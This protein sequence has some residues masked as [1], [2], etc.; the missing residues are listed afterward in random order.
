MDKLFRDL[1][2]KKKLSRAFMIIIGCSILSVLVSV[3]GIFMVRNQLTYFY[4]TPYKSAVAA[5]TYRRDLNSIMRN[6]LRS[7]TTNDLSARESYLATVQKDL[8]D[9]IYQV[10]VLKQDPSAKELLAEIDTAT[11]NL[12]PIRDKVTELVKQ[13]LEDEALEVYNNEYE[14]AAQPLIQALLAL[15]AHSE[16]NAVKS[17]DKGN[18][19]SIIVIIIL[20]LVSVS[21]IL[22]IIY[23][24]RVLTRILTT[25]IHE[26]EDAAES[27]AKGNLNVKI[28][29]ESKDELGGLATSL[30]KVAGL[31]QTIIPDIQYC[32]GE[33][34]DGNFTVTSKHHDNYIGSYVPILEAMKKI[35]SSLNEV[36]G[37]IQK[38]SKQVQIGAQNMSEGAQSLAEGTATQASSVDELTATVSELSLRVTEDSEHSKAVSNDVHAVGGDAKTSQEQ[39]SKV[40]SAME[41]ISNTSKQIEMIINSIEEIASQTNLLSLNASIEAARAGEAGRGFAVVANEIGKLAS[42][43]AQA[44]TN[45]RNLIQVSINEIE[46]GNIVVQDTSKFLNNVL[47]SI[48]GIV[49]SVNEISES[50]ERQAAFVEEISKEIDQISSATED[51]SSVAQESS[52]ISEE[53]FAQTETLNDLIGRFK[54]ENN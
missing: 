9:Q 29:Y 44:A 27:M 1:P 38:A 20:A 32:L 43:S 22:L 18:S 30:K 54:I 31:F 33:M 11:T 45:T 4:N 21:S 12:K 49:E 13:G 5:T 24:S 37:E 35:K 46:K 2:I 48:T 10:S 47:A 39:M 52:A 6:L 23:F 14:P 17:Y 7:I 51:N 28:T 8:E 40:V 19:I 36:L 16:D 25:P 50:T 42:E 41:N 34:A 3:A 53:L 15:G 26:L